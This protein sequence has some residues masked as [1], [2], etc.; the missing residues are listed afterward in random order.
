VDLGPLLM[1]AD[2][3]Q[4]ARRHFD[5]QIEIALMAHVDDGA[6]AVGQVSNLPFFLVRARL[7]RIREWES[8]G[9]EAWRI[10]LVAHG[11]G[12]PRPP[13][14]PHSPTG[15]NNARN[16]RMGT[17]TPHSAQEPRDLFDWSL[18]GREADAL[19]RLWTK[20]REPFERQRQV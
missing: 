5:R 12:C 11:A 18:S 19:Q 1:H 6:V 3:P 17:R 2:R 7:L 16:F 9:A 15:R 14:L 13:P 4:L 20:G 8:R 10:V